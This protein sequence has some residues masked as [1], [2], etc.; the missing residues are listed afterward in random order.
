[1]SNV[2]FLYNLR[3]EF[4]PE[5]ISRILFGE[6]LVPVCAPA[7]LDR[8]RHSLSGCELIHPSHDS[9]DWRRW[10]E[11]V[12]RAAE[13]ALNGGKIFDTLEQASMAAVSGYGFAIADLLLNRQAIADGLLALPFGEAVA[14]GDSYYFARPEPTPYGR[15][16]D[17]LHHHFQKHVPA[18]FHPSICLVNQPLS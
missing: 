2:Y 18:A 1:M 5:T 17:A 3:G 11:G 4:G 13:A 6:W 16:I 15:L 12:V 14:T 10:L 9:L 7:L 8:V